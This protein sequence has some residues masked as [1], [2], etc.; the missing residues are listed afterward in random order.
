M[1]TVKRLSVVTVLLVLLSTLVFSSPVSATSDTDVV[2]IN[3]GTNWNTY[4]GWPSHI[5]GSALWGPEYPVGCDGV[6]AVSVDVRAWDV[7]SG[8]GEVD[9][10]YLNGV[11]IGDLTGDTNIWSDSI[12][13]LTSAQ[14]DAIFGGATYPLSLNIDIA[15]DVGTQYLW[16]VTV[17]LVT[18]TIIYD[19]D[20]PP[21]VWCTEGVN[22]SGKTPA[23]GKNPKAGVN[24]D[25]FY[26]LNAEDDCSVPA[27][28]VVDGTGF[29]CG[30]FQPGD[31]VKITEAPGATSTCKMMGGANSA[32]AAHITVVCDPAIIAVDSMGQ[33]SV[34]FCP[35]P[36]PPK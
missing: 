26:Q 11:Y 17:D 14:I 30:P 24:P 36:L 6:T 15:V 12:F 8:Y 35:V 5:T 20:D 3:S 1:R 29:I 4:V 13:D 21:T 19:V 25:G 16:A 23:A 10:V 18:I 22:P 33:V 31:V 7:D 28:F 34:T 27:I 32:V 9:E 2:I